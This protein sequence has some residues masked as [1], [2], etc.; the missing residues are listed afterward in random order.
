MKV[1]DT[2]MELIPVSYGWNL[3]KWFYIPSRVIRITKTLLIT[4]SGRYSKDDGTSKANLRT[5]ISLTAKDETSD[6]NKFINH[7]NTVSRIKLSIV[8]LHRTESD[9]FIHNSIDELNTIQ[10]YLDII[11]SIMEGTK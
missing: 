9:M 8:K 7:V 6:R 2:V 10:K 4:K 1:G 3:S 5:K 11:I